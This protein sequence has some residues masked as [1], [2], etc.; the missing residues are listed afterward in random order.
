MELIQKIKALES[1]PT[2]KKT[3]IDLSETAGHNL[4]SEM[5]IVELKERLSMLRD[6]RTEDTEA[7]H[8]EII[9]EKILKDQSMMETLSFIHKFKNE[10]KKRPEKKFESNSE[11]SINSHSEIKRLNEKLSTLKV[12]RNKYKGNERISNRILENSHQAL[13]L[14]YINQRVNDFIF[15]FFLV[16]WNFKVDFYPLK[17]QLETNRMSDI[18]ITQERLAK[19]ELTI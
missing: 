2:M 7:K 9:Q 10:I 17:K 4:L 18:E 12:E 11:K 19:S 1:I 13:H 3:F 14:L 6:Q 5:T 8:D 15:E 16:F